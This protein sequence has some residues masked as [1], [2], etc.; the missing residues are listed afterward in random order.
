M[1][2]NLSRISWAASSR[3]KGKIV[4]NNSQRSNGFLTYRAKAEDQE[5]GPDSL[6]LLTVDYTA[7]VRA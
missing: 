1:G 7:K 2:V 6:L 4:R 3:K 5:V